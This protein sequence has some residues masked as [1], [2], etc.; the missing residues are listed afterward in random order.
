MTELLLTGEEVMVRTLTIALA[1]AAAITAGSAFS[2]S[3]H[4][5]GGGGHMG[6][7]GGHFGNSGGMGNSGGHF[8]NPGGMGN[9][10]GH[11][12]HP[13]GMGHFGH[14]RSRHD[15]A[16]RHHR[17][18]RGAFFGFG[19]Y[20]TYDDC[21]IWTPYGWRWSYACYEY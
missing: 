19:P 14:F 16:F 15:F 12:G 1:A 20:Y 13:M 4:M 9:S 18:F 2:A 10:G 5:G 8:G 21:R 17:F 3:A 6:G 11:F 7:S